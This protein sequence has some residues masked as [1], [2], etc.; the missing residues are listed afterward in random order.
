M[1][2]TRYQNQ[3][4]SGADPKNGKMSVDVEHD[5]E[6]KAIRRRKRY[7]VKEKLFIVEEV[8]KKIEEG[9]NLSQAVKCFQ[10]YRIQY[11]RWKENLAKL[12]EFKQINIKAKSTYPGRVPLLQQYQNDLLKFVF[13][14]REKGMGVTLK[15]V[16]MKAA[17]LPREFRQKNSKVSVSAG[18]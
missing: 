11:Y 6:E 1:L 8:N 5:S 14:L 16:M 15:M 7:S 17:H 18:A 2:S 12:N 13:E 10:I 3:S 4:F 9:T